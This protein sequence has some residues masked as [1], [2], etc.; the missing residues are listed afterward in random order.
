MVNQDPLCVMAK[1]GGYW[2]EAATVILVT[3]TPA[4]SKQTAAATTAGLTVLSRLQ[5]N[6]KVLLL[7]R[8]GGSSF[9]PEL[10]VFP[11]GTI[12]DADFD[13]KWTHLYERYI[14]KSFSDI[15]SSFQQSK[16]PP[17][18]F[19]ET[20]VTSHVPAEIAFRIC[21]IRECFEECGVLLARKIAPHQANGT[22]AAA[23]T[24]HGATS[25]PLTPLSSQDLNVASWRKRVNRNAHE[26]LSLCVE[27]SLVPDLWALQEW[28]NWLTPVFQPVTAPPAKPRRFDTIFYVCCLDAMPAHVR[29]DGR[30][31]TVLKV[32]VNTCMHIILMMTPFR[33]KFQC[34][35]FSLKILIDSSSP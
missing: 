25:T 7:K 26:F 10:H 28:C 23:G 6:Y 19:K 2:R 27:N 34:F 32:I 20:R 5:F 29:V 15:A 11:G 9:M 13:A 12:S 14:K 33:Q 21:A 22:P 31:T 3:K 18:A 16:C 4:F 17:P 24:G 30:E 8:S 1:R 35:F